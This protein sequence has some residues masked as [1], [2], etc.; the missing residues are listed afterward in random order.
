MAI[1]PSRESSKLGM[2]VSTSAKSKLIRSYRASGPWYQPEVYYKIFMRAM[3]NKDIATGLLPVFDKLSTIGPSTTFH[4]KNKIP[5]RPAP[6]CYILT[7]KTCTPEQYNTVLNE[8][9]IVKDFMVVGTV[10]LEAI[11]D[12][13]RNGEQQ[14]IN[15]EG[16]AEL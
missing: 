3:F 7:P 15:V 2:K 5:E 16:Q 11:E 1:S 14:V 9:A 6:K 13:L 4:V 10:D 12:T 8:T